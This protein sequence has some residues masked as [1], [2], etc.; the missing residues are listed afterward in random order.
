[1]SDGGEPMDVDQAEEPKLLNVKV[2]AHP[3]AASEPL[4]LAA[5]N[6]AEMCVNIRQLLLE[7][8]ELSYITAYKL[9]LL[10]EGEVV[11][12]MCDYVELESFPTIAAALA[13]APSGTYPLIEVRMQ[14]DEYT[15]KK[16]RDQ[17]R[18]FRELLQFPPEV[19][20][21][22]VP[23]DPEATAKGRKAAAAAKAKK[24]SSSAKQQQHQDPAAAAAAEQEA[25]QIREAQA[26]QAA[27]LRLKECSVPVAAGESLAAFYK[28][29]LGV[30][31]DEVARRDPEA[32]AA[33]AAG[34][35]S[36]GSSS[37]R[38]LKSVQFGP[39][40]PPPQRRRLLGD[41]LYVEVVTPDDG[42]LHLTCVQSGFYVNGTRHSTFDPTPAAVPHHSHE[43]LTCLISAS[44]RLLQASLQ[45]VAA[46]LSFIFRAQWAAAVTQASQ[47]AAMTDDALITLTELVKAGRLDA[48]TA[49]PQWNVPVE[50][51]LF[52]GNG[53]HQPDQS[54]SEDDAVQSYGVDDRGSIRDWNEEI[55]SVRAWPA[56]TPDLVE[57]RARALHRVLT[58]FHEAAVAGVK[59]IFEGQVPAMNPMEPER[60]HVYVFNNIFFSNAL[61]GKEVRL[62]LPM[63]DH[64]IMYLLTALT[65]L[66]SL[67]VTD[68]NNTTTACTITVVYSHKQ[69]VRTLQG[70]G[71]AHKSAA[72]DLRNIALLS[73]LDVP[74]LY[75]LGTTI[76]DYLGC[77]L[78]DSAHTLVH[79]SVEAHLPAKSDPELHAL[80]VGMGPKLLIAERDMHSLPPT[81]ATAA[82]TAADATA[83]AGETV[84]DETAAAVTANGESQEGVVSGADAVAAAAATQQSG[85]GSSSESESSVISVCGA[86]ELKGIRGYDSRRYLM[87]KQQ[88]FISI[89]V[90]VAHAQ[91]LSHIVRLTPR[92]A[93][94]VDGDGTGH[95]GTGVYTD[96]LAKHSAAIE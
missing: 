11:A 24:A 27:T 74:D 28:V 73:S 18:R 43:L 95:T 70:D 8:P 14:L 84:G 75:T 53:P 90:S 67:L 50:P 60:A 2:H 94:W 46:A 4:L 72:H 25:E 92:D 71:A 33:A 80:L 42:T 96:W 77:R 9:Q 48:V 52:P 91:L 20:D 93:N 51:A 41:L 58:D 16:A 68:A 88:Q 85:E 21:G 37:K 30:N 64:G 38:C 69:G 45:V 44:A 63:R 12:D 34:G 7:S 81:A 6:A 19:S 31:F 59:A 65:R 29:G 82:D 15:V 40:N 39:W 62:V 1:M 22:V 17:V 56:P 83:G 78:G 86:L 5:V 66:P 49:V 89:S 55:Q 36:A 10:E 79:G 23:G 61:D 26:Q 76:V 35:A 57:A 87:E 13:A 3:S 47:K 54:R 32:A